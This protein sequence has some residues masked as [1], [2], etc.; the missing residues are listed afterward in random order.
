MDFFKKYM[1]FIL[2]AVGILAALIF[3]SLNIPHKRDANIIERG[4]LTVFAPIMKPFSRLSAFGEDVWNNYLDLVDVR[5]ENLHLREEVKVLNSRVVAAEEANLANKRLSLLLGVKNSIK[6]PTL[7]AT[8]IGE[9]LSPWFGTLVIDRG[10]SS[11]ITEGMAVVAADGVVGQVVKVAP[12]SCRVLLLTDHS[13]GIAATIQRSRARG[14]VK[15]KGDGLCQLEFTTREEDVKVGDMVVSSGIGGVFM[16]GLPIGEV[17]MVK[18]GEYGIFQTVT[19]RPAVN[20]SHLEDV[21]V[22]LRNGND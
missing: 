17:T 21:L 15:G 5:R 8:V 12:A 20:I 10:S 9:D 19:I 1:L 4:I 2:A 6:E 3:Y 7:T 11:G 13:S 14:V 18:R 22:V 16:K